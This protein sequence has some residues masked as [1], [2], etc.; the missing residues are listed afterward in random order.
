MWERIKARIAW[1]RPTPAGACFV[2]L[3]IA[4]WVAFGPITGVMS[5]R[6]IHWYRK[7]DKV[8]AGLYVLANITVLVSI[9]ALTALLATRIE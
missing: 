3:R 9:P 6:A 1:K 4:P 2:A 8:L 7:G 5:E